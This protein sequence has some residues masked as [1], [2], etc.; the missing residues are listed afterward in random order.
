MC[1]RDRISSSDIISL[2]SS[3]IPQFRKAA[4]FLL[5]R[6]ESSILRKKFNL[7]QKE[8]EFGNDNLN[9]IE[10]EE[11][12]KEIEKDLFDHLNPAFHQF[13]LPVQSLENNERS[14]FKIDKD[15][16]IKP[17]SDDFSM[18]ST[19]D[20]LFVSDDIDNLD[21]SSSSNKVLEASVVKFEK[22]ML[23]QLLFWSV[24]LRLASNEFETVIGDHISHFL[25]ELFEC[26]P[27]QYFHI[28]ERIFLYARF[29]QSQIYDILSLTS[30]SSESSSRKQSTLS[31][32]SNNTSDQALYISP[33]VLLEASENLNDSEL[34]TTFTLNIIFMFANSFPKT[35]RK[36]IS[37][38]QKK[39][40]AKFAEHLISLGISQSVFKKEVNR[41]ITKKP[42]WESEE[43]MVSYYMRSQEIIACLIKDETT[44]QINI[45]VPRNYPL[46]QASVKLGKGLKLPEKKSIKWLLMMKKLLVNHNV[47][48][49]EALG[50]WKHN[51]EKQFD[52][53]EPCP[54]CYYVVHFTT[55]NM[56]KKA[57]RTCN[58]KFHAS[59]ISKWFQTS[60]K[61]ECPM[62]LSLIHI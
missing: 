25:V 9:D 54:I 43:F 61:A 1:I 30:D 24:L 31:M 44:I 33:D 39:K 52:G 29:R 36:F 46:K 60:S 45:T 35:L 50:I 48:I 11:K 19:L 32:L 23:P 58:S 10:I 20:L 2:L 59:C 7:N 51:L 4:F 15:I 53:I 13:F 41:I 49:T 14:L 3:R 38:P 17:S 18:N 62:C 55:K 6:S 34:C 28:L 5:S 27:L 57:C 56:P 37:S 47:A 22:K 40:L 16:H 42:I 21:I 8:E 12:N 26:N